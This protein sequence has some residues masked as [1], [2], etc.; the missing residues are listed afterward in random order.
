MA[1]KEDI[2]KAIIHIRKSWLQAIGKSAAEIF[3]SAD[4]S[5]EPD[6]LVILATDCDIAD[7]YF[8]RI[9]FWPPAMKQLHV[10]VK[11]IKALIPKAEIMLI[12]ELKGTDENISALGY[13]PT[14]SN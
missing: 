3:E 6:V 1:A 4:R 2:V 7:L 5:S 8:V 13:K 9:V 12:V 11:S 10:P 14:L